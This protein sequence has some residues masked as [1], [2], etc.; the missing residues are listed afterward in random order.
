M[1]TAAAQIAQ[2]KARRSLHGA[3]TTLATF[4]AGATMTGALVRE[5]PTHL[6]N[7]TCALRAR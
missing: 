5:P 3:M 2:G 4:R 7:S 6:S 1:D